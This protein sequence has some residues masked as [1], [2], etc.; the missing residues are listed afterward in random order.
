MS[1]IILLIKEAAVVTEGR[2]VCLLPTDKGPCF[3]F[4]KRYAF[5]KVLFYRVIN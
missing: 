5:N 2:D 1:I 3:G 4:A